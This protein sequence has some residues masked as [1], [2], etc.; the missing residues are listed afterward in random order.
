[1]A[2][3]TVFYMFRGQLA[4]VWA[5]VSE[6]EQQASDCAFLSAA[7][8]RAAPRRAAPLCMPGQSGLLALKAYSVERMI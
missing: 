4:R 8:R 1:M 2:S 3:R 7:P 5:F 6:Y